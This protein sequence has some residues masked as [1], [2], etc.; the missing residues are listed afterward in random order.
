MAAGAAGAAGAGG[1]GLGNGMPGAGGIGIPGAGGIGMPGAG[2]I[3]IGGKPGGGG[4]LLPSFFFLPSPMRAP[5]F[6]WEVI[7]P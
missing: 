4:K 1:A 5:Q 2:G 7:C 3:G 6:T